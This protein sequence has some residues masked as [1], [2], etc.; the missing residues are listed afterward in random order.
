[1]TPVPTAG[2]PKTTS[3]VSRRSRP[4]ARASARW[5]ITT[6]TFCPFAA[7]RSSS[8]AT[9]SPTGRGLVFVT[10]PAPAGSGAPGAGVTAAGADHPR[11]SGPYEA[12]ARTG[13]AA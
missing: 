12:A 13:R 8:R 3:V 7:S 9:V 1:M 10:A 6:K 4:T 2:F 11:W 5:S